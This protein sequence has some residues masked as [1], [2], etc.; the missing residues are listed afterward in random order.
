M[1]LKILNR[2]CKWSYRLQAIMKLKLNVWLKWWLIGNGSVALIILNCHRSVH[3]VDRIT[4]VCPKL[5]FQPST[6][7]TRTG[8][9]SLTWSKEPSL[10]TLRFVRSRSPFIWT[11]FYEVRPKVSFRWYPQR[12][13][14]LMQRS[15]CFKIVITVV[16]LRNVFQHVLKKEY[17]EGFQKLFGVLKEE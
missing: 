9:L 16:H 15:N 8:K 1:R 7:C 6:I 5:K 14:F 12:N 4:F 11:V 17:P 3:V 10:I 2:Q 13:R